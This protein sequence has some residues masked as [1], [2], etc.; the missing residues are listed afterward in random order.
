MNNKD[1][2]DDL[3]SSVRE[4][5]GEK[6]GYSKLL[7]HGPIEVNCFSICFWADFTGEHGKKGVYVKI[8]KFIL[9]NKQN[10]G[11]MPVS[12]DDIKLAEDEYHSLDYLSRYWNNVN[13]QVRFV[14]PL[15][16]IRKFNVIVTERIY[17]EHFFKLFRKYDIQRKLLISKADPISVSMTKLGK[18]LSRFHNK[19]SEDTIFRTENTLCKIDKYLVEL[20]GYGVDPKYLDKVAIQFK[21]CEGFTSPTKTAINLKG[22]DIRQVFIDDSDSLYLLDPGKMKDG[23]R[24]VDIARFIVTCRILYWGSMAILLH[25]TPNSFYEKCFL[26]GYYGTNSKSERAL[27]ILIVKELFKHWRM[28]CF[29]LEKKPWPRV[30]KLLLQRAYMDPFYKRQIRLELSKWGD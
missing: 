3:L 16:F 22:F 6:E 29:S 11:I 21:A 12:G 24:E 13:T 25:F 8:P 26:D 19:S 1:T 23:Y 18:A 28:A 30:C 15:A 5:V 27:S 20:K 14:K 9:Y 10:Q 17:A 7:N 2:F 4:K